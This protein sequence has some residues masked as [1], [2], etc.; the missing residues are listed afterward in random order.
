[1]NCGLIWW[2]IQDPI[3]QV[4]SRFKWMELQ[5]RKNGRV[6]WKYSIGMREQCWSDRFKFQTRDWWLFL[7]KRWEKSSF[8]VVLFM[9]VYPQTKCFFSVKVLISTFR[10]EK[11]TVLCGRCFTGWIVAKAEKSPAKN[12]VWIG[13]NWLPTS[14][15]CSMWN[16]S[17]HLAYPTASSK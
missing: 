4:W 10:L 17:V 1:M 9:A 16:Y 6:A 2:F 5:H 3:N 8:P 14:R 7:Q 12:P 13:K 11:Q 15:G